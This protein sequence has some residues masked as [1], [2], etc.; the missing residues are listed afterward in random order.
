MYGRMFIKDGK[1]DGEC[2]GYINASR[3][4]V[5]GMTIERNE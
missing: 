2:L 4:I 1:M 5:D 3:K